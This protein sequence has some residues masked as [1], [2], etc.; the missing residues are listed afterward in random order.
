MLIAPHAR[1]DDGYADVFIVGGISRIGLLAAFPRAYRGAHTDLKAVSFL[2]GRTVRI[3]ADRPPE[4]RA[5]G[6]YAG[7]TPADI[8]LVPGRLR[9]IRTSGP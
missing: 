4:I 1:P 8:E 3:E 6:E 2:R 9:I 5:D 7:Q